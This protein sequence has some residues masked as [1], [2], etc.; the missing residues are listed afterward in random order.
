MPLIPDNPTTTEIDA[1]VTLI[2]EPLWEFPWCKEDDR[3]T[4]IGPSFT[5]ALRPLLPPPYQM[6]VITATNPGS[7]KTLLTNMLT[8]LHGGVQRGEIP[9]DDAELRKSITAALMDTTAPIVVFDNL[10]GVVKSPVLDSLLTMK[11]WSDRWLG[12]NKSVKRTQRPT[13]VGYRQ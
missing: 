8:A 6:G 2:L 7:G 13:V 9:R 10:A 12:Q 4:W 1:A 11:V 5:P 3:A